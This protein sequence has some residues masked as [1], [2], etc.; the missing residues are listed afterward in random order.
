M[1]HIFMYTWG[2]RSVAVICTWILCIFLVQNIS[3][4]LLTKANWTNIAMWVMVDWQ[5]IQQQLNSHIG[6]CEMKPDCPESEDFNLRERYSQWIKKYN[7]NITK[8]LN[9]ACK[10]GIAVCLNNKHNLIV[11]ISD[12]VHYA[13]FKSSADSVQVSWTEHTVEHTPENFPT[14]RLIQSRP[15]NVPFHKR[16]KYN[17]PQQPQ[18]TPL[19]PNN[20]N[21]IQ[22]FRCG[23]R[24]NEA[25]VCY[26]NMDVNSQPKHPTDRR[27]LNAMPFRANFK[28]QRISNAPNIKPQQCKHQKPSTWN[29]YPSQQRPQQIPQLQLLFTY[30]LRVNFINK[31]PIT[32]ILIHHF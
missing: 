32:S 19:T 18:H 15:Q 11:I 22:C 27:T 26:S 1:V 28:P 25:E 24:R 12:Y 2:I 31:P 17:K 3:T 16:R 4:A 5:I 30:L 14:L 29:R 9:Q 10:I 8:T 13:G 23:K 20:I 6:S 7:K 21:P